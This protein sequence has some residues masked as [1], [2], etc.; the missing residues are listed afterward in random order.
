MFRR[1]VLKFLVAA[2]SLLTA[3]GS[4]SDEPTKAEKPV[5]NS[6]LGKE[7][8]LER[9]DNGLRM[10]LIWCPPGKFT[11]GS[12]LS[13][14][15]RRANEEQV[16]VTLDGFWIGKYEVTQAEWER[17][18]GT[19]PWRG[20]ESV[21]EGDDYPATCVSWNDVNKFTDKLTREERNANRLPE[22]WRYAIPTEAQW[23]Y[24][25][26]AG[27][28]TRYSFGE[29]DSRFSE[30]GWW[31]GIPGDGNATNERFA[32]RVGLKLPNPWGLCDIH[33]N[34]WEWC[35]DWYTDKLP[36]GTNPDG[37]ANGTFRVRRGGSWRY[38]RALCRSSQ[39]SREVP[40]IEDDAIGFRAVLVSSGK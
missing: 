21:R 27:T 9:D 6:M 16:A 5:G 1:L 36:G 19:T 32:H 26:R 12:P 22:G 28:S 25:C 40:Q 29:E 13:E 10:K 39:R 8:G 33:G 31:G 20:K 35:R 17:L 37:P 4:R 30:F 15:D 2:F 23:E 14:R 24:A 3:T 18:T 34:V 7:A 11:M 38:F